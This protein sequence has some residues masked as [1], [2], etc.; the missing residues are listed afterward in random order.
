VAGN[1]LQHAE[2]WAKEHGAKSIYL[3]TTERFH[4][5]HRFYR[6]NGY[7]EVTWSVLPED[8]P[9]MFVDKLFFAKAL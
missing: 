4:A 3:G 8:F 7:G 6:K 1:L 9:V 2:K 5:A